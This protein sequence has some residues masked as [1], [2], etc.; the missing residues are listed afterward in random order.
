M[1]HYALRC[2]AGH[3]FDG[4]FNGS[5]GFEAQA[6]QGL[7]TCPVCGGADVERALMSPSL[8]KGRMNQGGVRAPGVESEP[9]PEGAALPATTP[10]VP[11]QVRA[12]LQRLRTEVEKNCDY[13]GADFATVARRIHGG[14]E[15]HRPIYGEATTDEAAALAEEGIE[16][17]RIPWVPRADS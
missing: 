2:V 6:A 15:P 3:A 4:W 5:A 8:G 7:L 1:I 12:V 13:V 10:R 9:A 14:M 16:T 17:S 11:D